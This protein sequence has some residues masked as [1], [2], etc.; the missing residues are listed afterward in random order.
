MIKI[1]CLN[2]SL[3]WNDEPAEEHGAGE[4]PHGTDDICAQNSE[5][6]ED[7]A[8]IGSEENEWDRLLRV[9]LVFSIWFHSLSFLCIT[10]SNLWVSGV[11]IW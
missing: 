7:N 1:F 6:K 2:Q 11:G 8:V 9:R 4:S 5:R 3:D 10:I